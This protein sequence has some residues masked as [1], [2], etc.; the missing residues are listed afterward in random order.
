MFS[1]ANFGSSDPDD[2]EDYVQ[3][4]APG[5]ARVNQAVAAGRWDSADNFVAGNSP[6]TYVGGAND[7]GSPFWIDDTVI[8]MVKITPETDEVVLRNFDDIERDLSNYFFCTQAGVYPRLGNPAQAEILSGDLTLAPGEEV[9]VRVL[10]AGGVIDNTGGLFLFSSNVLGF[11]NTNPA[12]L[13]DFAQWGA[14]NGFRVDNAVAAGRWDSPASFIA[15]DSPFNYIGDADD[16]GAAFWE[17]TLAGEQVIRFDFTDADNN[18]LISGLSDGAVIDLGAF[19]VGAFNIQAITDPEIVG[20]VVFNISGPL[21][22]S[23]TENVFPYFLFGDAPSSGTNNA[24]TLPVGTYQLTATPFSG[25]NGTGTAGAPLTIA[26]EVVDEAAGDVIERFRLA[27]ENNTTLDDQL[28][29]GDVIDLSVIGDIPV[30]IEA[31]TDPAVVGSVTFTLTGPDIVTRT[32]NIAPYFLFGDSPISGNIRSEKLAPGQYQLTAQ[33]FSQPGGNGTPGEART[34][35]F[36][37]VN[38]GSLFQ[39]NS[40]V[41]N[42]AHATQAGA[43]KATVFPNPATGQATIVLQGDATGRTRVQVADQTGRVLRSLE[44]RKEFAGAQQELDLSGLPAGVYFLHLTMEEKTETL[45]LVVH[46]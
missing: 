21:N 4:G 22:Q 14:P 45:R 16:I 25:S 12:V 24:Q 36:E 28:E 3:W 1:E 2:L 8:R 40:S 42:A 38:G 20:S 35:Q 11:N 7:V 44:F 46:Q 19:D 39:S 23:P 32:E 31:I 29:D 17:A 27:D 33:P 6:Y 43:F 34:I 41:L 9:T 13:R 10:T 26:F 15:G 5:Q 30:N 37:V 18:V